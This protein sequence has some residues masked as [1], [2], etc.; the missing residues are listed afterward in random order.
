MGWLLKNISVIT[1]VF[2]SK[3]SLYVQAWSLNDG[4]VTVTG[5]V[6]P[7]FFLFLLVESR[8]H[9]LCFHHLN[10]VVC[11]PFNAIPLVCA[12]PSFIAI[13]SLAIERNFSCICDSVTMSMRLIWKVSSCLSNKSYWC[14]SSSA[15]RQKIL[16]S[17]NV[18]CGSAIIWLWPLVL[19]PVRRLQAS[20]LQQLKCFFLARFK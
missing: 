8:I 13:W 19:L 17:S 5:E 20:W 15:C 1:K 16:F 7:F 3:I 9:L 2:V 4:I 10:A 6:S 14:G 18:L 11:H 12:F